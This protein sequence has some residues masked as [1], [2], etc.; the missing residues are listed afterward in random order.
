MES[1]ATFKST[2]MKSIPEPYESSTHVPDEVNFSTCVLMRKAK[3][4][5]KCIN[6]YW[7]RNHF[8]RNCK[9]AHLITEVEIF[10]SIYENLARTFE[11]SV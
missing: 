1:Y 9:N 6:L 11:S 5:R 4:S 10:V 7:K 8:K 2:V 3:D